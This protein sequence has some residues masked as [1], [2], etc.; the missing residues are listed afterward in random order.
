MPVR[1]IS[2][3]D[4]TSSQRL[5]MEKARITADNGRTPEQRYEALVGK[6]PKAA[7]YVTPGTIGE[8][9]FAGGAGLAAAGAALAPETFGTSMVLGL[10]L[11][12][13]A[14][15]GAIEDPKHPIA[16]ATWEGAKAVGQEMLGGLIGKGTEL[17][18]RF[19]G[20]SQILKDMAERIGS[21]I[22]SMFYEYPFKIGP[23]TAKDMEDQIAGGRVSQAA[24]QKLDRFRDALDRKFG[25]HTP[26]V[27]SKLVPASSGQPF[28]Y[29]PE[30]PAKGQ[31][32]IMPDV[33]EDGKI[34][35]RRMGI[36]EA[37]DHVRELQAAGTSMAGTVKRSGSAPLLADTAAK[38][39]DGLA[40]QLNSLQSGLGDAYRGH[41]T[42][43]GL[44]KQLEKALTGKFRPDREIDQPA[45]LAKVR[46]AEARVN[47]LKP[48]Q[49]RALREAVSPTGRMA[50]AEQGPGIR[51]HVGESGLR[52]MFHP[53][54]PYKPE[55]RALLP[56]LPRIISD[57][58]LRP[59]LGALGFQGIQ[60]ALDMKGTDNATP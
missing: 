30:I 31:V 60:D 44:A 17:G 19:F 27:P 14:A 32:F 35:M 24:G 57:P 48:G 21:K 37:V 53:P 49:G 41:S 40:A 13:S 34:V 7:Q 58:K 36:K 8:A 28:R 3:S 43:Y 29:T 50:V 10:P 22:P 6:L 9:G 2:P 4:L 59:L 20:K 55:T 12:L 51:T 16:G 33:G 23:T 5:I 1:E 39:R 38:A 25:E 11:A 18:A 54:I 26:A 56:L 15:G 45:L 46:A 52:S 47:Q 42:D